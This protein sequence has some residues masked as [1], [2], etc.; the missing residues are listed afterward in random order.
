MN[1]W[2]HLSDIEFPEL[3]SKEVKLRIGCGVPEAFWVMDE[4]RGGRGE[5][6]AIRSLLCWTLIG[7]AERVERQSSFHVNFVKS[8]IWSEEDPLLLQVKQFWKNDFADSIS[9]SKVSMSIEDQRALR[10]MEDSVQR[11]A[12]RYQ[13]AFLRDTYLPF[14]LIIAL[15]LS[16]GCIC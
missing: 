4:R 2:P 11:V 10:I 5:P 12:G 3:K 8:Q 6:V 7:P 14:S 9:S 15:Q 1:S 16:N 13:V